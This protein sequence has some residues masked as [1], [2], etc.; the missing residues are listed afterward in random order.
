MEAG[1]RRLAS[2]VERRRTF[3]IISHPDAGKT[4]LTEKLLLFGGAVRE[5]GAV[6]AQRAARYATSDWLELEKQ[7]G[8][9]VSSSVMHF[10]YTPER[11]GT[12]PTHSG[13][14]VNI[15]DTPGHRDFSEDTYRTLLAADS[16]VML[17]DAAKGVE[18]QTR[19]LFEVCRLRH[20]P[21]FTFVN[22]MDRQGR[23]PLE[24]MAEIEEV[25]RI[26]VVPLSWPIG[27]GSEFRG[28]YDRLG[29]RSLYFSG[30]VHG[31]QRVQQREVAGRPDDPRVREALELL[32]GAGAK[33][34]PPEVARGKQTPLFFGSALTNFG[35]LPFLERFLELAPSPGPRETASGPIDP[36]RAEFSGFVFKIQANMDP[37][38]RDRVAFLRICSGR[39]E[40]GADAVIAR[41]GKPV[42]LAHSTLLMG[43]GREE[44]DEAFPGDVVGLFDPGVFRIGDSLSTSGKIVHPAIPLFS[45]EHF[46]RVEVAGVE[47]RKALAKGLDQLAQEGAV[48]IF[49]EPGSGTAAPVLGVVGPL[50]FDVLVHRME[51]EYGVELRL[52]A[53]PYKVA[54][55]VQGEFDADVLRYSDAMKLVADRDGRAVLLAE[56]IWHIERALARHPEIVLSETSDPQLR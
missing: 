12:L 52:A 4:T 11:M 40:R 37:D 8:I 24:L 17:I 7:R 22:K 45:P 20:I 33:F 19:K 39:F 21:I 41:T 26:D 35:V 44:V 29:E 10:D 1:A 14:R 48:Q 43:Q 50:Q 5:A 46:R 51:T 54:R 23:D 3:A 36:A 15:L 16:A 53:L 6:R 32:D 13:F 28:V 27:A 38:H 9:S 25:L 49:A 56:S 47:R 2:E 18:A 42:R 30:G 31:T 55:W 34:E